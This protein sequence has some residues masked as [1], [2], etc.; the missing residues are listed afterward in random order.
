MQHI[1]IKI[2][3]IVYY[4]SSN[5]VNGSYWVKSIYIITYLL[6]FTTTFV[7]YFNYYDIRLLWLFAWANFFNAQNTNVYIYKKWAY[8]IFICTV[9]FF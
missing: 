5:K 8:R 9:L 1:F 4:N 3:F 6:L 2:L 7:L